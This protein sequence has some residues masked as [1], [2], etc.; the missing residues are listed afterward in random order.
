MKFT[1]IEKGMPELPDEDFASVA[2]IAACENGFGKRWTTPLL[3]ER[4][5]TRGVRTERWKYMHNRLF[6]FTVT[7]W[8]PMPEPPETESNDSAESLLKKIRE[9]EQ[10]VC[11]PE[12]RDYMISVVSE[13]LREAADF[14]QEHA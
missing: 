13:A 10:A 6:P 8:A 1:S 5:L 11:D 14:I 3:Y 9:A 12:N 4:V 2:V 7:H